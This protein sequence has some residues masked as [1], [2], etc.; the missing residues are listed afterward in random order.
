M[1]LGFFVAATTLSQE[2][3]RV[4]MQRHPTAF[5]LRDNLRD[6]RSVDLK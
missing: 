4:E 6:F 5:A 2:E 1:S 3:T